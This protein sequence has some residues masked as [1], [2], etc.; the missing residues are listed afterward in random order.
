[1]ELFLQRLPTSV[2]SILAVV[3]D[4]K[5]DKAAEI[6]NKII[7]VNPSPVETFSVARG[8]KNS[9]DNKLLKEIERLH[10]RIDDISFPRGRSPF[11]RNKE[12]QQ[13]MKNSG[14]SLQLSL[15][16]CH[17]SND[18]LWC[19]TSTG[20]PRPLVPEQFRRQ[21]FEHLHN[22][23]HP[24]VAATTKLICKRYVWPHM[25]K[26]I[27]LWVQTCE[28]CQRSKI[29][30]H[31]KAP[32]GTL[33]LPDARFSQVHLDLMGPLPPSNGHIYFLTMIDRF[34]RWPEA[35]PIPG[36]KTATLCT[37][38]FGTWISRFGCKTTITTDRG[39]QMRSALYQEFC[40]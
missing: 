1:M 28:Q 2:Q 24:G 12:V 20:L 4:L 8:A 14:L 27:K 30:R 15:T 37:A 35:V 10:Q 16:P 18:D 32:L 31:T 25:K 9:L 21:I 13:Y 5:V 34:T 33:A 22:I 19:D 6:A 11:R 17:T 36:M 40:N 38:I 3:T 29:Q 7:E 26:K 39:A 23:S